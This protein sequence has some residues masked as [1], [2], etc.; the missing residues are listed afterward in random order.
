MSLSLVREVLELYTGY[1][2]VFYMA[3]LRASPPVE[4][5]LHQ[6]E[7]LAR[8][9]FR[10]PLR[11]FVADEIGL[12]KTVTAIAVAKR[13]RDLGLARR[14]LV[15]VP[16]VLVRQWL[17]ELDRFGLNPRRIE[18]SSFRE[19]A[20][21][22]FPEGFYVASMDLVKRKRYADTIASVEWD[23]VIVDE[24]HR[25]GKAKGR[26]PTQRYSFAER[27]ASNKERSLLLLSATP[28]RG[29]PEDYLSRLR[30]LDPSLTPDL[31]RL[32]TPQFYALTHNVLVFRRTKLDVNEVYEDRRVFPGCKISAVI[33]PAT[34]EEAEFH[35]RLLSFLRTKLL[36]Y[37][38]MTGTEPKALGLLMSLMFK[39]ASSS[40]YA[41]VKTMEVILGRRAAWLSLGS[42][43][44]LRKLEKRGRLARAVLGMGFEEYEAEADPD[45]VVDEFA[46]A[47]SALLSDRDVQELRELV[48]LARASIERDSRL[49][50]VVS[51]VEQHVRAGD[52]VIVF[53]EFRDTATYV[54]DALAKVLGSDAVRLLTSEEASREEE[55]A[56]VRLWLEREGGRVLVATDVASEGLNLQVASV[57]VNYEPPWSPVKLEQRIGRVWRLGQRRDVDVYTVFLAVDS[58]KDVLD[59][60]Y[61]KLV[62]MGR[63][64]GR[65]PKP[66][67]GEEAYVID[68]EERAAP[69]PVTLAV[70]RGARLRRVTEY[71]L[72]REYIRGGRDALQR[73]VDAIA[74]TIAQLQRDLEKVGAYRRP[75][76]EEVL[77]FM[78]RAVGFSSYNEAYS[79]LVKLAGAIARLRP[80]LV[81]DA[82]GRLYVRAYGGAL[83]P[84]DRPQEALAALIAGLPKGGKAPFVVSLG[85]GEGE[86][87]V[88]EVCI[89]LKGGP[90]LYREPVGVDSTGRVLRG[91]ELVSVLSEA[92]SRVVFEAQEF[93]ACYDDDRVK[94]RN[95]ANEILRCL[96]VDYERYREG[97]SHL[98]LARGGGGSLLSR[99]E[100]REPRLLGVIRFTSEVSRGL[101][102]ELSMEEKR[103]IEAEAMRIAL[104]YERLQGRDPVDVSSKEH[105]DILSRD[106]ST[107]EL[108]Y[109]EVK[110]HAGPS[111]LAELSEAEYRVALEKRDRY[112]LYIVCDIA[113]G[114]PQLVA[115]QDPLSKMSVNPVGAVKYLLV[116]RVQA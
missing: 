58:D 61:R 41:A 11:A 74:G 44:R 110:G 49:S 12:G 87:R 62:A 8:S 3:S 72:R 93:S 47:C 34:Q 28:H 83:R 9:L 6:A 16:R 68:L 19:L 2:P 75:S 84:L 20:A 102:G 80:D 22:G 25:V 29:D 32:N 77:T 59:V 15:I 100:V 96:T 5:Y 76:G 114:E 36:D 53:T 101:E 13:L 90:V 7:F 82:G 52:K 39:R 45:R 95:L 99:L 67:V 35:R 60:L 14:I 81:Q 92:L 42:A 17:L 38:R 55:L 104:E 91:A 98:G 26:R 18:R 88:Y 46:E 63:A 21:G 66:P 113:R 70:R 51:L 85:S 78:R 103:R 48:R 10:V 97:L 40:P 27:I 24:A 65:L 115:V 106:P 50:A 111:L 107:E 71:A 94:L 4:P 31:K 86:V 116:P 1:N 64:L 73:L 57:L 37:H 89:A 54:R 109:I 79:S 43:E 105:F 112:W 23:L 56:A 69:Q 30:L 33:V 108:R